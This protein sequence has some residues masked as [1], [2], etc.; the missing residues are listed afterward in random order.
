MS[1]RRV[2]A[3]SRSVRFALNLAVAL[4]LL[5][6]AGAA[7][8]ARGQGGNVDLAGTGGRHAIQGR[9]IFPSGKRADVRLKVRLESTGFGDLTVVSDHNGTFW[10]RSL[11]AGNYTVV[12]EGGD[13]FET[14]RE[15]IFIEPSNVAQPR[16]APNSLS[17]ARPYNVQVYLRPKRAGA[18]LARPG[19]LN[20]ALASAPKPAAELYEKAVEAARKGTEDGYRKAVGH[21]KA[22][23][24]IHPEFALAL[25]ELGVLH[26]KLK[27]P[28][29][30]A[31]ALSA[32]LELAPD[33]YAAL[34]TYG[35]ALFDL[36]KYPESE[37]QFRKAL[38][39]NAASPSAHFYV[40]MISLK[41]QDLDGAEKSLREAV[42]H[43][44]AEMA[45]A[46]YYLGGVY[47]GR[48]EYRRAADELETYLRLAPDAGN[49]ARVRATIKE[50]RSKI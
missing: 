33:D 1:H 9:L 42:K 34:I 5:P 13:D 47:W 45:V 2:P 12:V 29:K 10:F 49:A 21:L 15:Q 26:M 24:A 31:E 37:A 46:H 25:S 11:K 18:E 22:A 39:R 30:A 32:A 41:R 20:A 14:V 44:G 16:S 36:Q 6:A 48:K 7:A 43:G 17:I 4:T 23:L 3:C 50:L 38:D 27:E 8:D 35:R 28:A 40:G 19:V